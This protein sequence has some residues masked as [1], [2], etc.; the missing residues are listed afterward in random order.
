MPA[1]DRP[2]GFTL[3]TGKPVIAEDIE[4]EKRFDVP[5]FLRDHGIKSLINV[6]IQGKGEA[7]RRA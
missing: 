4:N 6:I 5:D 1:A 7:I 2:G 3:Y